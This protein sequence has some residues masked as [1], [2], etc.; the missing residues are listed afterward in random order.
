MARDD[1]ARRNEQRPPAPEFDRFG[2]RGAVGSYRDTDRDDDAAHWSRPWT[3]PRS[4]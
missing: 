2:F 3:M 1:E 4:G